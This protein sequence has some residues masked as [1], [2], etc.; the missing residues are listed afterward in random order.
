VGNT[1][2]ITRLDKIMKEI[3]MKP[4]KEFTDTRSVWAWETDGGFEGGTLFI[5]H[6]DV[7]LESDVPVQVF[8]RDP[9]WLYGEGIGL[10]RAPLVMIEFILRALR[11][12][13]MLHK[14][15]I[16]I[17]YYLDEGR[18]CRYSADIIRAATAK[19]GSVFILRPG[20]LGDNITVQRRGQ[21][22]YHL[23]IEGKPQRIGQRRKSPEVLLWFSE[24]L[25]EL[26]RFS[27]RKDRIA[28]S[29]VDVKTDSFPMLLPH[30][31]TSTLVLS[32]LDP[33]RA[34]AT[35]EKMKEL[36]D[37]NTFKCGLKKI[38]ERPPMKERRSSLLL[39]KSLA[40]VAQK[41]EIPLSQE[42]S[43][44]P[45]VGG[46][47]SDKIPVV[48]GIGPVARDL[49]TPQEAVNRISLIQRTLLIAEFL[50]KDINSGKKP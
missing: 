1:M 22:K 18:D 9:E 8:R 43:V 12:H 49:C 17:L 21:R 39:A 14:L 45:S 26:S 40:G 27:S 11:Y 36:F 6:I 19:G 15:P 46:L 47:V 24:K 32:Y 35:E 25:S 5:G 20:I 41:W 29:A 28:L 3:K 37:K 23:V 4:V 48:C 16:G 50:A 30:R 7:P 2:A 42:S 33:E 38:S 34:D 10:S 44:V 31:V 13:R